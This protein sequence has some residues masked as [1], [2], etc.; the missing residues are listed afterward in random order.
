[1]IGEKPNKYILEQAKQPTNPKNKK[2]IQ[3]ANTI[4]VSSSSANPKHS[5]KEAGD[6]E[7]EVGLRPKAKGEQGLNSRGLGGDFLPTLI[8]LSFGKLGRHLNILP[9][10]QIKVHVHISVFLHPIQQ[11]TRMAFKQVTVDGRHVPKG[12]S[13]S[14]MGQ[15]DPTLMKRGWV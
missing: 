9:I 6:H 4:A 5:T 2:T 13:S 10:V 15:N 14:R 12:N 11:G 8:P 7:K 3:L 1:M